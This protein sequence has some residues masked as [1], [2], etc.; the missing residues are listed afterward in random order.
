MKKGHYIYELPFSE[1]Q[2]KH[3]TSI[4]NN[5]VMGINNNLTYPLSTEILI[6][7]EDKK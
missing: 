7:I 6:S 2:K 4:Y 3:K 5:S 1:L